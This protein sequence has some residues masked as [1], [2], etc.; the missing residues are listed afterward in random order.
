MVDVSIYLVLFA[1]VPFR[2]YRPRQMYSTLPYPARDLVL[3]TLGPS[4]YC[5][6]LFG[7]LVLGVT[8]PALFSK[9]LLCSHGQ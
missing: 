3:G 2:V 6:A 7:C 9:A 1:G 8:D 4:L 5:A